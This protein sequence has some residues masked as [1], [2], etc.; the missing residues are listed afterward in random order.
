VRTGLLALK[1]RTLDS[2]SVDPTIKTQFRYI[3]SSSYP[4][5]NTHGAI[6]PVLF[7]NPM[8][9]KNGP[10]AGTA[11]T[12]TNLGLFFLE[13]VQTNGD[14]SGFFVR[15]VIAG[16]TPIAATN[17]VA[18]SDPLFLRRWLPMSVQLLK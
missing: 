18:D 10:P 9:W 15:E 6:I 4:G 1:Y 13:E 2:D 11:F 14:I 8:E 5:P 12:V 16:G 17:M 7:Y 3:K